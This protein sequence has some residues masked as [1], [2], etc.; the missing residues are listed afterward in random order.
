MTSVP[1]KLRESEGEGVANV[2]TRWRWELDLAYRIVKWCFAPLLLYFIIRRR[3]RRKS[4]VACCISRAHV[5]QHEMPTNHLHHI[6][7]QTYLRSDKC[8]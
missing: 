3:P 5:A 6:C 2:N 4:R 1:L 7:L 8:C